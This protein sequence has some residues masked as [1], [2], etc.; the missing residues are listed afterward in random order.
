MWDT[1]ERARRRLIRRQSAT[2]SDAARRATAEG[3]PSVDLSYALGRADLERLI[4]VLAALGGPDA[5]RPDTPARL[6]A[7]LG[8]AIGAGGGA[9]Q[10][11]VTRR[12]AGVYTP[13]T[14]QIEVV[15]A[16]VRTQSVLEHAIRGGGAA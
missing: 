1:L 4:G 13:E 6:Q 12:P 10:P 15:G 8:E 5:D 7:A 9:G 11:L 16:D 14:W 2:G 3:D